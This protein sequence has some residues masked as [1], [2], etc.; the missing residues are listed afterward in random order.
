MATSNETELVPVVTISASYGAGGSVVAPTL[1]ERLGFGFIDRVITSELSEEASGKVRSS[2][3]VSPDE[4]AA[5]PAH[6]LFT[7]LARAASVGALMAPEV[8]HDDDVSLRERAESALRPLLS[9]ANAEFAGNE[10]GSVGAEGSGGAD[11]GGA[12]KKASVE[13]FERGAVVLGR[14]GAVVLADRPRT[15]HV[16]LDGPPARRAEQAA[17]LEQIGLEHAT[18]RLSETD[19]SRTL[20]VRRL[21]GA[22]ATDPSWYHLWIDSTAISLD[23][24]MEQIEHML[25]ALLAKGS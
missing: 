24:V 4:Q 15:L 12:V 8:L 3:S 5:S 20:W 2:E 13:G 22:D 21:Y 19:R 9:P 11:P 23:A 10:E 14:A 6:R 25:D 16:R 7:Y 17:Q 1:A 18:A